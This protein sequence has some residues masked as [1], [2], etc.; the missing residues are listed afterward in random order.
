MKWYMCN[1]TPYAIPKGANINN[2]T[3][4]SWWWF[5]AP[6]NCSKDTASV[7]SDGSIDYDDGTVTLEKG[8]VRPAMW[9][10]WK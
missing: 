4:G 6:G 3:G 9:I 7:N 8:T 1:P 10:Y 5:R 2:D